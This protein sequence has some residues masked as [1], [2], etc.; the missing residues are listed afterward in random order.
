MSKCE[1]RMI[2]DYVEVRI[3]FELQIYFSSKKGVLNFLC[4][5]DGR[6][7]GRT[8]ITFDGQDPSFGPDGHCQSEQQEQ[9]C[10]VM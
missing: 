4:M 10:T 5:Y 9:S 6:E 7:A 1:R 8:S 3:R 2:G